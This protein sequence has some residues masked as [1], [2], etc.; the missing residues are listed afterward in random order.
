VWI[1]GCAPPAA[2][3]Q[4]SQSSVEK[5]RA[6]L[7]MVATPGRHCRDSGS[8]YA[9]TNY[10]MGKKYINQGISRNPVGNS[11]NPGLVQGLS[12]RSIESRTNPGKGN[13]RRVNQFCRMRNSKMSLWCSLFCV[14]NPS[15]S[16][17]PSSRAGD[18]K[19]KV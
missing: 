7:N 19:S 18:G 6:L 14:L 9:C 12:R 13:L 5:S 11:W 4:L 3:S 10:T 17:P 2:C 8:T 15:N 1:Q 16:E